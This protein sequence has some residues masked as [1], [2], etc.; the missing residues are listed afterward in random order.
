MSLS[1]YFDI[2]VKPIMENEMIHSII[3]WSNYPVINH[4]HELIATID[5]NELFTSDVNN[6]T[7]DPELIIHADK[8]PFECL[9]KMREIDSDILFIVNSAGKYEGAVT[10]SSLIHYFQDNIFLENNFSILELKIKLEDYSLADLARV[11]ESEGLKIIHLMTKLD[12]TSMEMTITITLNHNDL[13]SLVGIL[14]N[15]RYFISQYYNETG[16]NDILKDRYENLMHFL[17]I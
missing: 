9:R 8:H 5:E 12:G 13:K 10:Y 16:V 7:I 14:E 1:P 6:K 2:D 15:K 11:V 3:Q 17:N 4:N